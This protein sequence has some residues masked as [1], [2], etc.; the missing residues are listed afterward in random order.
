MS[1]VSILEL[2]LSAMI[3]FALA[4]A[5]I[6]GCIVSINIFVNL[7]FVK[8][9]VSKSKD[10]EA[11]PLLGESGDFKPHT[12]AVPIGPVLRKLWL[13]AVEVF[14]IFFVTLSIFPGVMFQIKGDNPSLLSS[15]WLAV[16][17]VSLFQIFDY[18]GRQFTSI[19]VIPPKWV[20]L[21]VILRTGFVPLFVFCVQPL[22]FVS[23]WW[24]WSFMVVFAITN[25]YLGSVGMMHGPQRVADH[26][27][28]TAGTIMMVFLQLGIFLGLHFAFYFLWQFNPDA[29]WAIFGYPANP[30][31]LTPV[32]DVPVSANSSSP[33]AAPFAAPVSAPIGA[34]MNQTLF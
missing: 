22:F 33:F 34:P 29:F 7:P 23:N 14:Y 3:Y 8:Y 5:I 25:G 17:Y 15:G 13:E 2:R 26:Q 18:V 10:V 6:V 30:G 11:Q 21:P 1:D 12:E 28:E 19:G 32:M 24:G 9:Y 16:I 27:K 4:G 20:W 31:P